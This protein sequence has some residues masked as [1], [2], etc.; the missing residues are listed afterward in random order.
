MWMYIAIA[1][2]ILLIILIGNNVETNR[3][4]NKVMYTDIYLYSL[5]AHEVRKRDGSNLYD[6]NNIG[7]DIEYIQ[8]RFNI[9]D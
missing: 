6:L 7:R 1:L 4:M 8:R 2:G 9:N 3:R 5:L